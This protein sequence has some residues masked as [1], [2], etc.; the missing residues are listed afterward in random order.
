MDVPIATSL[1]EV[2]PEDAI[3][4][5][6][7]RWNNLITKFKQQYGKLPDFI[8][9]SPGRVNIIGEHIDYCLYEV[10]PMAIE[11]DVLIAVSVHPESS[12]PSKVRLVNVHSQKFE[13]K[14]FEVPETGDVHIDPSTLE[15]ANYF[16]SGLKG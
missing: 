8:S 16:K 5:Q 4:G 9:R 2:Y 3:E 10:L 12:G 11:A 1:K 15:W 13:N 14:E 6:T 7:K